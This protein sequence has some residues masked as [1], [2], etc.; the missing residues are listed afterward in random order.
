MTEALAHL[1]E[2]GPSALA[3]AAPR[4]RGALCWHLLAQRDYGENTYRITGL[5]RMALRSGRFNPL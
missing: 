2:K 4:T 5:G 3:W 1:A